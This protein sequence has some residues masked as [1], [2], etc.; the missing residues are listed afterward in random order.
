MIDPSLFTLPYDQALANG[1]TQTGH[2]VTLYGRRPGPDDGSVSGVALEEAFYRIA[3]SRPIARLPAAP[4]LAVK[5]IDHLWSMARLVQRLRRARPEVIHFQWLPLPVLDRRMLHRFHRIAPLVLTVHDTNPFN[6]DPSSW[7]QSHG[8]FA[9]LDQFERL[10]VHTEQGRARL[11]GQGVPADRLTIVPHGALG[12]LPQDRV[13]DA[14]LGPLSFVLFGKIKPYKGAD[15][16]LEAFARLPAHLRVQAQV[17]II[18]KPYMDLEPLHRLARAHGIDGQVSIEPRFVPDEEVSDVYGPGTVA[19][20]PYREIDASGVL[21]QAL[22]HGRPIV[23]T[24]LGLFAEMLTDGVQGHLNAAQD[25]PALTAALAHLI[26]DRSFAAACSRQSLALFGQI[27][28]W[29]TVAQRTATI[30]DAA[31]AAGR[32]ARAPASA[33]TALRRATDVSSSTRK[34]IGGNSS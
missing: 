11:I 28:S 3:G 14:M 10:I 26:E 16:L 7:L 27:A 2:D 18:G 1:L 6:G 9:C 30:Y 15:I 19:L 8:Y 17:R 25:V 31:V 32:R 22:A 23:A 34:I 13:D 29:Q 20:F 4:R 5:G 24:R 21:F 12:S 33:L